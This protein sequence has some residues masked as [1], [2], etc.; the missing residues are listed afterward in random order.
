MIASFNKYLYECILT[1]K[2]LNIIQHPHTLVY[3]PGGLLLIIYH[4]GGLINTNIDIG[5]KIFFFTIF[6][7]FITFCSSEESGKSARD[8]QSAI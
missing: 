1:L 2:F 5:I 4:G 8:F 3:W 6:F 7:S